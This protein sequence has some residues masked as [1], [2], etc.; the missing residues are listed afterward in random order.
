MLSLKEIRREKMIFNKN[1]SDNC[2]GCAAC[3][4]VCPNGAIT[5]KEDDEGF[6]YPEINEKLCTNCL[7]CE[8]VCQIYNDNNKNAENPDCYALAQYDAERMKSSSGAIFPLMAQRIIEKGGYVSGVAFV[9]NNVEHVLINDINEID[10]LRGSK[11]IQSDIKDIYKKIKTLLDDNKTVL[12]SGTPCQVEGLKLYLNKEYQNLYTIDLVCH[13]VS[14]KK[15]YREYIKEINPDAKTYYSNFRDKMTGWKNSSATTTVNNKSISKSIKDDFYMQAFLKDLALR[16]SCFEC[17]YAKIQ[18]QGDITLGDFWSIKKYK[19]SL[20]DD[21]GTSLVLVNNKKGR[22]LYDLIKDNLK[23]NKKVPLKYAIKGNPNLVRPSLINENREVFFENL[24][25]IPFG[26]NVENAKEKL[27]DCAIINYWYATNYGAVLTCYA[28]Q[29][30]LKQVGYKTKVI[31]YS[32]TTDIDKEKQPLFEEFV[33]KH[34]NLTQKMYS[35]KYLINLNKSVKNF[36]TGSDQVFRTLCNK[37]NLAFYLAFANKKSNKIAISASFGIDKT[38]GN[39]YSKLIK[40]IFINDFDHVS[41]RENAGVKILKKEL[42]YK[43]GEQILD[44]VFLYDGWEKL[45]EESKIN[46]K[47]YIVSY[48]FNKQLDVIFDKFCQ[49]KNKRRIELNSKEISPSDW[50]KLMKDSDFV[51]T[52]SFHGTCFALIFKKQFISYIKNG[53][54]RFDTL[55]DILNIGECFFVDMEKILY[56]ELDMN[57]I[58]Y[59][60]A[61]KIIEIEKDKALKWIINSINS[62]AKNTSE[63]INYRFNFLLPI[64]FLLSYFYYAYYFVR[65]LFV[66][67]DKKARLLKKGKSYKDNF[68]IAVRLFFCKI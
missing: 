55:D 5:M 52:D 47:N 67:Q 2:S 15:V 41:T 48:T 37:D 56:A 44:P 20:D 40:R 10:K 45:A 8:K 3:Y 46:E 58:D 54:S 59:N 32:P 7:I 19:K 64:V 66:R 13:G 1:K 38:D 62:G 23:I 50:V 30:I 14:S 42:N 51:L 31:N 4:N 33:R 12:F 39:F 65:A 68:D 53:K 17:K 29:E 60:Q 63:K 36:I 35:Y 11:Y 61:D 49:E 57:K 28:L 22:E 21:K 27:I 16:K 24:G 34:L 6:L 9:D 25:A 43:K 26:K 18:R